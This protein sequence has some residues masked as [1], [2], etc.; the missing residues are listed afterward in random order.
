MK[1]APLCL[2]LALAI[3]MPMVA[4]AQDANLTKQYQT[5]MDKSDGVTQAMV[6]CIDAEVRRQDARLNKAYQEL[7][8]DLTTPRKKQLQDAQRAWL[9]FRDSNCDFYYDPEGGTIARV[10]AVTCMMNLTASRAKELETV[11]QP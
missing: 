5:C 11:N 2:A 9:K 4:Q 7:M 3:A 10:N 6:E 1:A 8:T